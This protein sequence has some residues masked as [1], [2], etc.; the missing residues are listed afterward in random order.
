MKVEVIVPRV[1]RTGGPTRLATI[2]NL[3]YQRGHDVTIHPLDSQPFSKCWNI[4]CPISTEGVSP[5]TDCILTFADDPHAEQWLEIDC[6]HLLLVMSYGVS[7]KVEER[8]IKNSKWTK[9]TTTKYLQD[10]CKDFNATSY[11]IGF[12]LDDSV[13]GQR[14]RFTPQEPL[15]GRKRVCCLMHHPTERKG[16]LDGVRAINGVERGL[17][18]HVYVFGQH[19]ERI[20]TGLEVSHRYHYLP[21]HELL[22]EIYSRSAV[23]VWC[24]RLEG[25]GMPPL[26]ALLC[27]CSV[28]T[29]DNGGS[30]ELLWNKETAEVISPG[31]IPGISRAVENL[32]KDVETRKQYYDNFKEASQHYTWNTCI[33]NIEALC[34]SANQTTT[35]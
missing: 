3:L 20:N 5:Y 10:I 29:Y 23:F 22:Q 7:K 32:L 16:F 11:H 19:E 13:G 2:A 33:T 31:N 14:G 8:N 34:S 30:R 15:E 9:I 18:E 1:V 26:E 12:G 24:S 35:N 21:D 17:I 27:G 28:V 4:D 6:Q 25:L